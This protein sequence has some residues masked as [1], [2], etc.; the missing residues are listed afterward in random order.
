MRFVL[1]IFFCLAVHAGIASAE[2]VTVQYRLTGLFQPDRVEDLRQ[3]TSMLQIGSPTDSPAQV[4]LVD[5]NYDTTVVTFGYDPASKHFKN[6][7]ADQV[8]ERI[9]NVLRNVSKGAFNIFSV[10]ELK[11]EQRKEE[12]IAVAGL[13]CKGCAYGAYR[14]V[15][16][17][18]GV[19]RATVS[20]KEGWLTASIDPARTNREALITALEKARVTVVKSDAA[21]A[22]APT[23]AKTAS[24]TSTAK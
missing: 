1:S 14:T 18:D 17:I 3:Q 13:D 19:E 10:S 9:S 7:K 21:P 8:R 20:F 4:R 22:P 5:V 6:A 16:S 12:R 11:P 2:E 24:A 15:A 23:P